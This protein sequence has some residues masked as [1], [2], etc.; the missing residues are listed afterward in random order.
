[1]TRTHR[2]VRL[3]LRAGCGVQRVSRH[4]AL[5]AHRLQ[6]VGG[7]RVVGVRDDASHL[8]I[9]ATGRA[10][11]RCSVRFKG[12]RKV[13]SRVRFRDI[14]HAGAGRALC[15]AK[16]VSDPLGEPLLPVPAGCGVHP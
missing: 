4:Q 14:E 15:T 7:V 3:P 6:G 16:D 5:I 2:P 9:I 1:M 10:A 12:W 13:R 11:P 8:K